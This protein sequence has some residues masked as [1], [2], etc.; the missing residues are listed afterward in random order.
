MPAMVDGLKRLSAQRPA[1]LKAGT[2][3]D[4]CQQK[5]PCTCS[6]PPPAANERQCKPSAAAIPTASNRSHSFVQLPILFPTTLE[7]LINY[8]S[9]AY[10]FAP[11]IKSV[12]RD[13]ARPILAVRAEVR[14]LGEQVGTRCL[15]AP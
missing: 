15:L 10:H 14:G 13:Y 3:E 12:A 8:L 5:A 11:V 4:E 9:L 2:K 6:L 7:P 1:P